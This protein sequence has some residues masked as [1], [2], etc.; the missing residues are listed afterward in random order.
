MRPTE[1]ERGGEGPVAPDDG[2]RPGIVVVLVRPQH[3]ANVGSVARVMANF[4]VTDLHIV[5]DLPLDDT[6]YRLAMHGRHVL[7]RARWHEAVADVSVNIRV[8]T[9]GRFSTNPKRER[10]LALSPE[11][12][13]SRLSEHAGT[14]ALIF[15]PEDHGL[16]NEEIRDCDLVS[17]IPADPAYP[18]L[19]LSHAVAI[20]LY[21]ISRH[22]W[23]LPDREA[24]SA[25]ERDLLF[26]RIDGLLTTLDYDKA[27]RERVRTYLRR[28]LGRAGVTKWEYHAL[29]GL[30]GDLAAR[31]LAP[32]SGGDRR[33]GGS[34][35]Q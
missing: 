18:I 15:G 9:T 31:R 22:R 25:A 24:A 3:P 6:A 13:A 8:A 26:G 16:S 2:V 1:T 10:R 14:V 28:I 5:G 11:E 19:N 33:G 4:G 30:F 21:E 29:M 34:E 32:V 20:Y 35:R 7:D 12:V 17:S 27:R 23:P